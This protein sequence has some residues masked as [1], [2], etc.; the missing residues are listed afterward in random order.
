[1]WKEMLIMFIDTCIL[2]RW[3]YG[4]PCQI[5]ADD[6]YE[7]IPTQGFLQGF[8]EVVRVAMRLIVYLQPLSIVMT[9]T[10]GMLMLRLTNTTT[11]SFATTKTT[12]KIPTPPT[13]PPPSRFGYV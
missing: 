12:T 3:Q 1:M 4:K 6:K 7:P 11:S 10:T 13:P 9:M 2:L 8:I 5:A